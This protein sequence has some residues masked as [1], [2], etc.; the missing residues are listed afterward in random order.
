M[1]KAD[2]EHFDAVVIGSGF[3]G[4][5]A[6]YRL[7]SAGRSVVVLERGKAFPPGSFPRNPADL[8]RNFWDPSAGLHGMFNIWSFRGLEA[9]VS[10]G[11][12]GGSLIYANVLLR[13]DEHWFV[14]HDPFDGGFETWP[15]SRSD[16]DPHYDNVEKMMNAQRY[17]FGSDGYDTAK[18]EAMR[19]AA[20]AL[21]LDWQLPPLAVSFHNKDRPP[22]PGEPLAERDFPNLHGLP[23]QTCRLCGECDIGCNYGSKNTLDHN[24]LSAA[25]HKGAEIRTRSEVRVMRPRDGGGYEVEYVEHQQ[26]REGHETDTAQ[27][28][29]RTVTCDRLVL[30][31]GT[32]GSTYLLLRNRSAFPDISRALGSRFCGNG[33]LLGF[34]VETKTKK[35]GHEDTRRLNG[36]EGPVI[37]SAIRVPDASDADGSGRGFYIEDAGFPEFA[38]WLVE[39]TQAG[40]RASRVLRLAVK[41]V[42]AKVTGSSE[43]DWGAEISE[44]L[45]GAELSVSSLPLLGMGRDVPDGNMRLAGDR[46][47]ID[48]TVDSSQPFFD[49]VERTMKDITRY[50]G[51]RFQPNLL[52]Y[53]DRVITVHPLGGAP[54][55]DGPADGVINE[56]AEVF[57]YPGLYV[58]DGSAM[59]GPVGANPALTIA[60]FADRAMERAIEKNSAGGV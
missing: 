50:L 2:S 36:A 60:A 52:S 34:M 54:M 7:A 1:A 23:R 37:T 5:V 31:A 10:A 13:K 47:D 33:D 53:L 56:Y 8:S 20:K 17:P 59:P 3:G 58:V 18:T 55:A 39:S 16:L 27:L 32:M 28:Q 19:E 15:I 24:Y 14:H 9:V 57:G 46:L 49:R 42:L 43:S 11:L 48:W 30:A 41:R 22:V 35:G 40:N 38:G 45:G 51:G 12:G 25:R 6:G 26:D 21:G 44:A 4:S 29:R